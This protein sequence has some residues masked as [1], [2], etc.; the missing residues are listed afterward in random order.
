MGFG[1]PSVGCALF[2]SMTL[3]CVGRLIFAKRLLAY[4]VALWIKQVLFPVILLVVVSTGVGYVV[5]SAFDA[6]LMRLVFTSGLTSIITSLIGWFC[7]L[8]RSER[9]YALGGFTKM[10][11]KFMPFVKG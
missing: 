1:L 11:S 8:N 5:I 2:I 10:A 7:L 6:S 9:A 4:P 3:Y